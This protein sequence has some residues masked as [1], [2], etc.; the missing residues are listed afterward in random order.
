MDYLDTE[1]ND[2]HY[3]PGEIIENGRYRVEVD[4]MGQIKVPAERLW[5]AQT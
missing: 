1:I 2:G 4:S 3:Q 5:G